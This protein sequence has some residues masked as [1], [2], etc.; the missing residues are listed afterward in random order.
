MALRLLFV[1]KR[2]PPG[3]F[4]VASFN[5]SGTLSGG[6]DQVWT[7]LGNLALYQYDGLDNLLCVEQHGGVTGTGCSDPATSDASSPWR[8]RRFTYDSL[9]RLLTAHNP[10][11]G[12]ISY[13]YDADGN[14]LQKTSPLANQ[15]GTATQIVSYCYDALH[16]VTGKGYGAQ[17]CPLAAPVVSYAYDSG[18]GAN[19]IGKLTSLTDQAGTASYSYD[20]LGRLTAETRVISGVSKSMSYSYN[21]DSSL[22]TLTNPSGAVI[23]YTPDSAGRILSAVDSGSGIS[24]VTAATY[25]RDSELTGF[26]SGNSGTFAGITNAYSYNKRLQPVNM[27]ATAPSQTVYSIGY[28]F[29]AGN[30]TAATGT[31]NGNVFGITN[32]KDTTRNQSFT[33]DALNRLT[34]A[35]NA[36]TN[37]AANT[38]N[39]KTEYWGNSYGYDAWGNLLQKSVTKCS[40]ENFSVTALA[41][42]QLSGYGYDAAGNMTYDATAS[43][44]Y[45]YDQENRITGASGYIY[46]YDADGNRVKKSNGTTGTI[47]WYMT[48]GIVGESDLSGNLQSEYVFFDGERVARKDFP[49]NAISYYFSDQLKTASVITDAS[50][51]IKA[52]SDY[53]PWGGEL[54]FVN[55]DSN[56]YKFG[57]HEHD[58]ETGLDYFGARYYSNGLGRWV[59][60]DWSATPVPVPYADLHDPQTLNLYAY[61]RNNTLSNVDTDGHACSGVMG[62][63]GSGF[64]TRATEYGKFDANSRIQSQTRFFGAANAVSQALA[65]VA[66]WSP[67]VRM[68]G[69]SAQTASFLEGVGEKLEKLN[70]AEAT[71]IQNGS[72]KGPNLDQQLVHNEQSSVQGQLDSLKQSDPNAYNKTITEINGA[73]NPGSLGK[74]AA[75]LFSTDKAFQGVLDG[76]RKDLGRNVDFSKQSDREAIGNALINHVRQTGG[77]DVN[78]KKESGC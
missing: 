14:L 56:H 38:V 71:A 66:A 42:N 49:S 16:R 23:T 11:S 46:G 28:D 21:L 53:Y 58:I 60:A 52:E 13:S 33:Y 63:T 37:C 6:A 18:T 69:V 48:P 27:S 26:V 35:Q 31:D 1:T 74:E 2:L 15:T 75:S 30:G 4:P 25:G 55:N 43:L 29:H 12:T 72:L 44:N 67:A 57:G 17:S 10:E 22:K 32:Y 40:A 7:T 41:N 78:G 51:V 61:V 50:G 24:Y 64:C 20:S 47:Y 45:T 73:L 77:C 39:G 62:N 19:A 36:G 5:A 54:Q 34:S 3:D 65:D 76:V 70:Q 9:G 68:N 59:S 8:V